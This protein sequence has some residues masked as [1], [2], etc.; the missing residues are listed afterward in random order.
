MNNLIQALTS[1]TTTLEQQMAALEER[2]AQL[3]TALN[4]ANQTIQLL[5]E[6]VNHN[7]ET[8]DLVAALQAEVEQLKV[9]GALA[10]SALL[11]DPE[12]EIELVV[13]DDTEETAEPSLEETAEEPA[14]EELAEEPVIEEVVEEPVVEAPQPAAPTQGTLFGAP[15]SDIRQAISIGDRFLFQRELFDGNGEKMQ[16]TL[17]EIN[18]LDSYDEA[19]E[20]IAE[21]FEWDKEAT[22]T[23]LFDNV[24]K[25]R[26]N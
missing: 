10:T 25:R 5:G 15:V 22:A 14:I 1:Y 19:I 2:V 26:F 4:E 18:A 6:K 12:V 16:K 17:D 21:H 13:E 8:Q 23:Q 3:E 11:N 24:L 20:Y 9:T 7:Q